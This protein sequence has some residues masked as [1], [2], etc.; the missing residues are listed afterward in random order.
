MFQLPNPSAALRHPFYGAAFAF[1]SSRRR[2]R[3]SQSRDEFT[4]RQCARSTEIQSLR[5]INALFSVLALGEKSLCLL[6]LSA[7][8]GC[9]PSIGGLSSACFLIDSGHA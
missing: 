2:D 7:R 4:N 8:G 1:S 6:C 9:F 5:E 3:I